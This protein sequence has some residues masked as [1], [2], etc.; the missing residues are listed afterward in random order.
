MKIT[1]LGTSAAEGFPAI[2]CNCKFCNE[3]RALGG[4]NIRT[5]SQSLINDDMLIDFPQDTYHHFLTGNIQ[6]DKIKHL[7][8]TH[9]HS[10]HLYLEDLVLR[11]GAFAH[12]M[13]QERLNIVAG[14]NAYDMLSKTEQHGIT[15]LKISSYETIQLGDYRVTALP[16]RHAIGTGAL[17][18]V[19]EGE[20]T[21]LYAHDTGFLFDEVLEFI[22]EKRFSF[23]LVSLD[24]TNVDIPISDEGNHMGLP[25]IRRLVCRL[26]EIRAVSELTRIVINHFSHNAA[27]FY[28]SLVEAVRS[29]GFIVSYDTM[30][31]EV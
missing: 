25:N 23:D 8:I 16:A 7:L 4:K 26:N 31:L 30:T 12:N 10:D 24:C 15:L 2:F 3:A 22:A 14:G 11:Y 6:G 20:K 21:I 9:A 13:R 1:Y 17:I 18:Y 19:I 5:R 27:P 29:D 28:D